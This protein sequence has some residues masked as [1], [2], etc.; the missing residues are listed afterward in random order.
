M[1]ELFQESTTA[2]TLPVTILLGLCLVYWLFVILGA[3][4]IDAI[5]FGG[6]GDMDT[7]GGADLD[8]DVDLDSSSGGG[9]WW[10][11][12]LEFFNLLEIPGMVFLSV[13]SLAMWFLQ[14][15]LNSS[16]NAG[17]VAALGFAFLFVSL[18]GSAMI[19]KYAVK[20]LVPLFARL[21][22]G[23]EHIPVIGQEGIVKSAQVDENYGQVE[24]DKDGAPLLLN[25][26]IGEGAE[27]LPRGEKVIVFREDRK[28]GIYYVR[29]L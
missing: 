27:A 14:V 25:A 28:K 13:M 2:Y 16:F 8:L 9:G 29:K 23:E 10:H 11:S 1:T 20:P 7:G 21:N 12:V 5:D 24:V 26:R 19:A 6:G 17:D 3:L 18:L 15:N 22:K 4:D